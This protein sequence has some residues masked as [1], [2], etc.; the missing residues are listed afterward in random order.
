MLIKAEL[1]FQFFSI[2]KAFD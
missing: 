2:N 1:N